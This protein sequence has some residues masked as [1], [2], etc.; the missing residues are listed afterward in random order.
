MSTD[1]LHHSFRIGFCN[2]NPPSTQ[3]RMHF[4]TAIRP[5]RYH[6]LCVGCIFSGQRVAWLLG[7]KPGTKTPV[8]EFF[9]WECFQLWQLEK[10]KSRGPDVYNATCPVVMLDMIQYLVL[11]NISPLGFPVPGAPRCRS[12]WCSCETDGENPWPL[13]ACV[14]ELRHMDFGLFRRV[15]VKSLGVLS[16]VNRKKHDLGSW[17]QP[18]FAKQQ[19]S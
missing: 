1:S 19:K 13:I 3:G 4:G 16:P 5:S 15:L 9:F 2:C 18:S 14:A 12:T 11:L 7:F 8:P 6:S 10:P 17:G